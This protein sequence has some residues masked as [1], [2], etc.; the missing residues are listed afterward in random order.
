[1]IITM[2]CI[3]REGMMPKESRFELV[4][5]ERED[6]SWTELREIIQIIDD[7]IIEVQGWFLFNEYRWM[8]G[9]YQ[10]QYGSMV[11]AFEVLKNTSFVTVSAIRPGSIILSISIGAFVGFPI[12][13]LAMG[14]RE[15]RLGEQLRQLGEHSGN[16]LA[17]QCEKLNKKLENYSKR[18]SALRNK[19]IGVKIKPIGDHNT[20]DEA[21][22]E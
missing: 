22:D 14:V 19:K 1:M 18:S 20:E 6:V 2:M 9:G 11:D 16:I 17:D 12:W 13:A 4:I 7:E 5:T 3:S 10:R 21:P 15:S 8:R